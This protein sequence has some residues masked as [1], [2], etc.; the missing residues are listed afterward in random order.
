MKLPVFIHSQYS[1]WNKEQPYSFVV[2]SHAMTSL[3][4]FKLLA[5][6]EIEFDPPAHGELV[7]DTISKLREHKKEILAEAQAKVTDVERCIQE[8]LCLEYKPVSDEVAA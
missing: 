8:L 4:E 6:T 7:A 1:A 2:F 3:P 5:E